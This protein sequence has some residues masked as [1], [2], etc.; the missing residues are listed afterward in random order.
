[1]FASFEVTFSTLLILPPYSTGMLDLNS[2]TSSTASEL[3]EVNKPNRCDGLYTVPPLK[4]IRFWSV[5]PPRTLYPLEASPTV[6]TPG[7]VST[8]F[9]M[10]DS[11]KADGMFFSS[12]GL[13]F[14]DPI[15]ILFTAEGRPPTTTISSSSWSSERLAFA[16]FTPGTIYVLVLVEAT[17]VATESLSR[18]GMPVISVVSLLEEG[19][20]RREEG[21]ML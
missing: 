8:I 15:I 4:R 19:G 2:S 9:M 10:S 17:A 16:F 20:G 11:P 14:S 5:A 6:V 13:N 18:T 21:D 1:M 12:T 7:S 3:N